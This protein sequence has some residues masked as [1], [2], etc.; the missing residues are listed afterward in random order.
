MSQSRPP[1]DPRPSEAP[2]HVGEGRVVA[3]YDD[4]PLDEV[5]SL[6]HR[7]GE[8]VVVLGDDR[9]AAVARKK[10]S[11]II[12]VAETAGVAIGTVSR[13]LNGF[14]VR[15]GNRELIE[16][17]IDQLGYKRNAVAA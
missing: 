6:A 12:D 10:Q 7:I 11:T 9:G 14:K 8:N 3:L 1:F 2:R 15:R 13:Y 16:Q 5:S 4:K 17:A